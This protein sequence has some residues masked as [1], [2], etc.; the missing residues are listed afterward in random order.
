[1]FR[2]NILYSNSSYYGYG[3]QVWINDTYCNVDFYYCDIQ[4][5]IAA[6]DGSGAGANYTGDYENNIDTNPLFTVSGDH[7]YSIKHN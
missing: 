6:F 1:M 5:G 7:A 4:G 2:N 3:D